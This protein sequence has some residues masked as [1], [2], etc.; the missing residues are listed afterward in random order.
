MNWLTAPF[1]AIYRW[2][3]MIATS[4]AT[5]EDDLDSLY[6][7]R[8]KATGQEAATNASIM[9]GFSGTGNMGG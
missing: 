2:L 1:K 8:H 3:A 7:D 6:P 5:T 4:I 9:S